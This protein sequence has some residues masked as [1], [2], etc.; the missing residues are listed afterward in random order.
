MMGPNNRA[1]NGSGSVNQSRDQ[2]KAIVESPA[3]IRLIRIHPGI[4]GSEFRRPGGG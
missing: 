2:K 1:R 3:R 4:T